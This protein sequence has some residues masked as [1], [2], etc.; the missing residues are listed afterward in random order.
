MA[1]RRFTPEQITLLRD[2]LTRLA[3]ELAPTTV[4]SLYYQAVLSAR[5]DFIT[6][7]TNGSKSNYTAVQSRVLDLRQEG[8]TN[9]ESVIDSSRTDYSYRR[10][11]APAGFAEIAPHYYRLD[12]WSDQPTRP[13]VL[14]EKHG[15]VPVYLSHAQRF[16]VDV[17]T[18]K[19]YGSSGHLRPIREYLNNV[20]RVK[21]LVGADF[22]PS[23]C[24]RPTQLPEAS[25]LRIRHPIGHGAIE[26]R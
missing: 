13:I 19:G 18:C 21:V 22:D 7:D 9:W 10:W 3:R 6:K 25:L 5:L 12:L 24:A 14:V 2:E 1:A 15:Q 23:G 8:L 17:W 4:R 20:Q 11:I 16:G 26:R